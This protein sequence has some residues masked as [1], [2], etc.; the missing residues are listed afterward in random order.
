MDSYNWLFVPLILVGLVLVGSGPFVLCMFF[1]WLG[2]KI[3]ALLR[4]RRWKAIRG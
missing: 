3:D 2:K 1:P 4:L